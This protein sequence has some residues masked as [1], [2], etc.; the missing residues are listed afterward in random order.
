MLPFY[1]AWLS[2]LDLDVPTI[3]AVNGPAIGA[4]L[5]LALACDLRYAAVRRPAAAR[6]SSGS[7]CT[8]GMGATW[9]LPEVVGPPHARDLLLTGRTVDADEALRLG[10]VSRVLEP[11][12]FLDEVLATAAGDRRHR[13]AREPAHH[14]GAARRRPRRPRGGAA[15]GGA[16]PAGHAGDR[17]PP[18]GHPCRPRASV[19]AVHRPLSRPA[20]G[21]ADVARR[22]PR[23]LDAACLPLA[24]V[25]RRPGAPSGD[26][27]RRT[28]PARVNVARPDGR[29]PVDKPVDNARE[30]VDNR[31]NAGPDGWGDACGA[32]RGPRARRDG[33][34]QRQ[35]SCTGC[36]RENILVPAIGGRSDE[37]PDAVAGYAGGPVAALR[38]VAFLMERGR[39]ETRRVQAFRNAAATILPLPA[40]RGRRAGR[41]RAP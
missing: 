39:E 16:R 14:P 21:T 19:P 3:A 22:G 23:Y 28:P 31:W 20:R 11:E 38:R 37:P 33:A 30:P 41:G 13:A 26:H 25:V 7:A 18:G 6:R 1:R 17:R 12:G 2:V 32:G 4:G 15:V 5:C 10:L 40:R 9:L 35:C 24:N 29:P 36:G 8:P 34:D 27:A